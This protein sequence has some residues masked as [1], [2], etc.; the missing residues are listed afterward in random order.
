MS[1]DD[2][3]NKKNLIINNNLRLQILKEQE[4]LYGFSADP[5]ILLEIRTIEERVERL[6]AELKTLEDNTI[7]DE[8]PR[9]P[10]E[11]V[12]DLR[13][14]FSWPIIT[15]IS[16]T[17]PGHNIPEKKILDYIELVGHLSRT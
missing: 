10:S 14:T 8:F 7:R 2:I 5:K 16:A 11:S 12:K 9:T 17:M 3:K 15:D 1:Y 4:A 6:Q 13:K